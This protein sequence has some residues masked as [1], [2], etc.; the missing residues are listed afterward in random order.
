MSQEEECQERLSSVVLSEHSNDSIISDTDIEAQL[1]IS[2]QDKDKEKDKEILKIIS[3]NKTQIKSILKMQPSVEENRVIEKKI[4][5]CCIW[6]ITLLLC[7]PIIICDVYFAYNDNTCVNEYPADIDINLKQ[8]LIISALTT[9]IMINSYMLIT[10]YSINDEY[11]QSVC[12]LFSTCVFMSLLG[13]F[14]LVWNIL[15]AFIFWGSIYGKGYCSK[16]LTTYLFVS[17]IIKFALSAYS[18]KNLIK[19]CKK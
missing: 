3:Q 8:Y 4:I 17:L 18:Y 16:H 11:T 6:M 10:N 12:F 1:D 7:L 14:V 13:L 2:Q 19:S 9:F 5:V 15:G